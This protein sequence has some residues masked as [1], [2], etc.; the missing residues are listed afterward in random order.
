L[1][2]SNREIDRAITA[3]ADTTRLIARSVS[4]AGSAA[5][6]IEASVATIVHSVGSASA[7]ARELDALASDLRQG[8]QALVSE[9]T[10][11]LQVVRAA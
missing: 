5:A 11:F 3:E 7:S 1:I 9:V 6:E 8:A 2:G 10:G 4:E